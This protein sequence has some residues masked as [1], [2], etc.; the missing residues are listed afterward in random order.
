MH[1]L[2][3]IAVFGASGRTGHHLVRQLLTRGCEVT[4]V[5]RTPDRLQIQHDE[6]QVVT[7][8]VFDPQQIAPAIE[9]CDAVVSVLG[10]TS[11]EHPNV[12]QSG[13]R[14]IVTAMRMTGV[15]RLVAV[16]NSAH[17]PAEGDT[18]PR[19]LVQWMLNRVVRVPFQ[20]VREMER[21]IGESNVEW[22]ILRPARMTNGALSGH[23]RTAIGKH[24]SGGWRISRADV[25]DAILQVLED[26]KTIKTFVGQAY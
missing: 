12:L 6:L 2:T 17:T 4:A 15:R 7:A 23:Y 1:E 21:E 5:V 26:D 8:D 18:L 14:S 10:G 16:S 19:K 11:K 24:V 25:A 9:N 20:D 3:K 13:A 22:T